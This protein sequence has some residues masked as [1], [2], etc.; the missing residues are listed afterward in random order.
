[1]EIFRSDSSGNY[2]SERLLDVVNE[3]R[4]ID[5]S[6]LHSVGVINDHKGILNVH[7]YQNTEDHID[8][9]YVLSIFYIVWSRTGETSVTVHCYNGRNEPIEI[10]LS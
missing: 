3:V 2:L 6:I 5:T 8:A 4:K 9:N 1:M 10:S 7:L